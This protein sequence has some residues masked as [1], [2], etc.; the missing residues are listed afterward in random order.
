MIV[1]NKRNT[2]K[3]LI[4]RFSKNESKIYKKRLIVEHTINK[5]KSNR[6]LSLRYDT[7][8]RSF[9]GFIFLALI[10]L[11]VNKSQ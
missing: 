7:K 4:K 8:I 9:V 3:K 10:K 11:V 2:K 5:V 1:K 6:R